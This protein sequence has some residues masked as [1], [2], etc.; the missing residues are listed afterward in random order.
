MRAQEALRESERS[1]RSAIDG[2]AGLIAIIAP[3]GE[4]ETVNRQ[5][6][7]YFGR[8]LEELKNWGT[9]DAVHPEDLPHVVEIF[10]RAMASGIPY[11]YD[12]RLR[13]FDGEY[14]W[15]E[16]RG[17]PIRDDSGRIARWYVLLTDIE[18][19]TRALARLDQMQS[20]LAHMNRL[21]MMGEL[22]ASIAYEVNQPIAATVANA[23]AALRW[24]GAKRPNLD[25]AQQALGRI[26]RDGDSAGA[27]VRRIRALIK[28]V[29]PRDERVEINAAI[30]DVMEITH[31]EAMK[32]SV[33]V[34]TE[35]V[36]G[37]PLV[38]GDRVELQQVIL[39]LILNALEAMRERARGKC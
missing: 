4:I 36:E 17:V 30:R 1:A 19:R 24:L 13:R 33:S 26:V 38:Q 29:P 11:H 39:N 28:K 10:T 12:Q 31:S 9:N 16:N 22:T 7:E 2:I 14:R 34:R 32:N 23:Q 5:V 21:S 20:D 3:N 15:F 8:S 35:L 25:E 6:F 37:L 27:V 18:D